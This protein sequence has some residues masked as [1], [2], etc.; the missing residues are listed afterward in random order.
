MGIWKESNKFVLHVNDIFHRI[1]LE[2]FSG[3]DLM[4][5]ML[6]MEDLIV[7]FF[8]LSPYCTLW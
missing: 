1:W 2:G 4:L 3:P 5:G 7:R 6:K 8:L